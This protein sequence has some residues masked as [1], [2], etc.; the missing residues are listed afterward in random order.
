MLCLGFISF[1]VGPCSREFRIRERRTNNQKDG[2]FPISPKKWVA[3][4]RQ[5]FK[6]SFLPS[7]TLP[8]NKKQLARSIQELLFKYRG[9]GHPS[10]QVCVWGCQLLCF[11]VVRAGHPLER[12]TS[13]TSPDSSSLSCVFFLIKISN[14]PLNIWTLGIQVF[15]TWPNFNNNLHLFKIPLHPKQ[16]KV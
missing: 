12:R 13:S 15:K 9:G 10:G 7:L 6:K 5:S 16:S 14:G 8:K 3:I 4:Q 2:C 1:A 11:Q